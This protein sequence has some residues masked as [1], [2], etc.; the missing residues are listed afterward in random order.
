MK[1]EALITRVGN[2][3]SPSPAVA[4]LLSLLTQAETDND[5]VIRVVKQDSVLSAKLLGLC[6]SAAFGLSTPIGSVDQAVLY[7]GHTEIHRLVMAI[8]FGGAL[9]TVLPGYSMEETQLWRHS[10]L[11]AFA[12][13]RVLDR[14]SS[15][16][17]DPSVSY[18]AG[19]VHDI[20]KIVVNHALDTTTRTSIQDL[21]ERHEHSLVEA[22]EA[23][24]GTDH[25]EIGAVLLRK[26][27]LPEVIV[28]AVANH[29]RPPIVPKPQLSTVVHLADVLAHEVGASPGWSS[30][31]VRAE[32]E[33]VEALGIGP[34]QIQNLVIDTCDAIDEVEHMLALP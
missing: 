12:T 16:V 24:L 19:L 25:A 8:S 23:V 11:V 4:S 17:I 29:H 18:T 21:V 5:D 3:R 10:L 30:F 28:E 20:G 32:E 22:E 34:E 15:V 13:E 27:R 2:L 1:A 6:N 33:T 26:W 7:L 31:A 9:G 14:T